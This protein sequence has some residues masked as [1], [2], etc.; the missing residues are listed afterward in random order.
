MKAISLLWNPA[1]AAEDTA[2]SSLWPPLLLLTLAAGFADYPLL[3]R[4]RAAGFADLRVQATPDGMTSFSILA[5]V[6]LS[7]LAAVLLPLGA[8]IAGWWMRTYLDWALDT[9]VPRPGVRRIVAWGF[10]PL[11]VE[12]LGVGVIRL[13]CR[14]DCNLVNPLATNSAFFLDSKNVSIFWYECARGVDVFSAWTVV[15]VSLALAKHAE[16]RPGPVAVGLLLL[17]LGATL[18]R[19]W[20]LG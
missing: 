7:Y 19:A 16:E 2:R 4:Y 11:T 10:L 3:F 8:L 6:G 15:I 17:W 13:L 20:L 9:R 12:R 14:N 5:F 18:F 1:G